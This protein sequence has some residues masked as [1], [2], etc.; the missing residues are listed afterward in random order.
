MLQRMLALEMTQF[1]YGIIVDVN[2]PAEAE[3]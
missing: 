2:I 1:L 3:I